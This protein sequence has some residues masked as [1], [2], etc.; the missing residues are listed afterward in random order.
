MQVHIFSREIIF[1][2]Y[3]VSQFFPRPL[4]THNFTQSVISRDDANYAF[5][6]SL[7]LFFSLMNFFICHNYQFLKSH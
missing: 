5:S 2:L 6:L 1:G 3:F 7:F 4:P